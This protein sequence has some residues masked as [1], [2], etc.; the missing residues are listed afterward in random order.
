[1]PGIQYA[2]SAAAVNPAHGRKML[3]SRSFEATCCEDCV[4]HSAGLVLSGEAFAQDVVHVCRCL[5]EPSGVSSLRFSKLRTTLWPTGA[6][7]QGLGFG[8]GSEGRLWWLWQLWSLP[9]ALLC[10]PPQAGSWSHANMCL[11]PSLLLWSYLDP[12]VQQPIAHPAAQPVSNLL[13]FFSFQRICV[14]CRKRALWF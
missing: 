2:G 4:T 8:W 14:C 7:L 3:F 9:A 10:L 13:S 6:C 5:W 11:W 1:M 12:H